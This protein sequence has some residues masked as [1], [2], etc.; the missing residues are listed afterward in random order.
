MWRLTDGCSLLRAVACNGGS[1]LQPEDLSRSVRT[2]RFRSDRKDTQVK[3]E[4]E[5]QGVLPAPE[6]AKHSFVFV[7]KKMCDTPQTNERMKESS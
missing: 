4:A 3:Q 6:G 2:K 7:I 5:R 1:A